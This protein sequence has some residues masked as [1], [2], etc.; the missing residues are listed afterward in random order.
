MTTNAVFSSRM[1]VL[2]HLSQAHTAEVVIRV[3]V[4]RTVNR[5]YIDQDKSVTN[6]PPTATAL[7]DTSVANKI[8]SLFPT[9]Q[10]MELHFFTSVTLTRPYVICCTV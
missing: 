6:P 3:A 5:N 2:R 7:W 10:R 8:F 4:T 9:S 1:S